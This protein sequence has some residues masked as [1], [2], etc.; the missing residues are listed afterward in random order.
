VSVR[1]VWTLPH[2]LT[3]NPSFCRLEARQLG[4]NA[5]ILTKLENCEENM[6]I[7]FHVGRTPSND[8]AQAQPPEGDSRRSK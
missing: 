5:G 3:N 1:N 2:G 6:S 8:Q 4:D 7:V